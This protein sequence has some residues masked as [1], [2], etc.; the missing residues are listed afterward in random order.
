MTTQEQKEQIVKLKKQIEY[1][2]Q[3]YD[4]A[5]EYPTETKQFYSA[6]AKQEDILA[7]L[8]QQLIDYQK[9]L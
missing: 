7:K 8:K 6:L 1:E 4:I 9:E 3:Q 2:Q 5:C